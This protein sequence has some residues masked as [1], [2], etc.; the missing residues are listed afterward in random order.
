MTPSPLDETLHEAPLPASPAAQDLLL[1]VELASLTR[2]PE[3]LADALARI[4]AWVRQGVEGQWDDVYARWLM[5]KSAFRDLDLSIWEG[6]QSGVERLAEALAQVDYFQQTDLSLDERFALLSRVRALLS[7]R[8]HLACA[9]VDLERAE[10]LVMMEDSDVE[11]AL[12]LCDDALACI[13]QVDDEV[14][15]AQALLSRA[16]V[17]GIG[18]RFRE[19]TA[20]AEKARQI[21]AAR[22]Q[23]HSLAEVCRL[24]VKIHLASG[25]VPEASLLSSEAIEG[26]RRLQNSV[27]EADVLALRARTWK[28]RG[29]VAKA[30]QDCDDA[31]RLYDRARLRT[32]QGRALLLRAEFQ[33]DGARYDEAQLDL[34]AAVRYLR[35]SPEGG[36][37]VFTLLKLADIL[38]RRSD[39]DGAAQR[40]DQAEEALGPVRRDLERARL[41][42]ETCR[43][44]KEMPTPDKP[45]IRRC[46]A[47]ALAIARALGEAELESAATSYAS[48]A[49]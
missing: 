47:A 17:L 41:L 23:M 9:R 42:L 1:A 4:A 22:N 46:S 28:A 48:F 2:D 36:L 24:M 19:A 32:W 29:K 34:E 12:V 14:G 45:R 18:A 5:V 35:R 8:H 30:L 43:I 44:S 33:A 27:G 11:R 40:L 39:L 7:P 26:Y 13:E 3:A 25:R 15:R 16:F 6:T 21:F 37:L 10:L 38:R 31:V 49:G 20:D